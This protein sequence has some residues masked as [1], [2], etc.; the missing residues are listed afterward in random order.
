VGW[1]EAELKTRDLGDKRRS[2]RVVEVMWQ[3]G[4]RPSAS[5]P[6]ASGKWADTIAVYRSFNNEAVDWR[7]IHEAHVD[8]A[9]ERMAEHEVVLCIQDTTELDFNGRQISR[10]GPL[11]YE[12]RRGMYMHPTYAVSTQRV[13]LG[14]L[15][16]GTQAQEGQRQAWGRAGQPALE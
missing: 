4:E 9:V 11:N 15:D 6:K 13:L 5:V 16:V 10:L 12:A 7:D 14:V 2:R 3:L 8:S 1:A